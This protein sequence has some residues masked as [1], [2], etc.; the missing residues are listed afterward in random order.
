M[1]GEPHLVHLYVLKL[2]GER[3]FTLDNLVVPSP[4]APSFPS[5]GDDQ[6]GL[7]FWQS[8]IDMVSHNNQ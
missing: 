3:L 7:I 6:H 1:I 4:E 5:I 8:V 2:Q